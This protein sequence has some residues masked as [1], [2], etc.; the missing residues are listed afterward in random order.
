MDKAL[1]SSRKEFFGN[2]RLALDCYS[3]IPVSRMRPV[4]LAMAPAIHAL[5]LATV[6][7]GMGAGIM[8]SAEPMPLI[9]HSL[10]AME[11][12]L[13]GKHGDH[14][15]TLAEKFSEHHSGVPVVVIDNEALD[16]IGVRIGEVTPDAVQKVV[17]ASGL[18]AHL[19]VPQAEAIAKQ[20]N[21]QSGQQVRLDDGAQFTTEHHEQFAHHQL[22]I[23]MSA[24][25]Q[26]ASPQVAMHTQY[27]PA[28]LWGIHNFNEIVTTQTTAQI[29]T[30]VD[31]HEIHHANDLKIGEEHDEINR[32]RADGHGLGLAEAVG[33]RLA[34]EQV[35]DLG[36]NLHSALEHRDP[37][38]IRETA[39][40]RALNT[41]FQG[42]G[43]AVFTTNP[44]AQATYSSVFYD[45]TPALDQLYDYLHTLPADQF[46]AL[47]DLDH[48]IGQGHTLTNEQLHL[49]NSHINPGVDYS[50]LTHEQVDQLKH[51]TLAEFEDAVTKPF[52]TE[53][54]HNADGTVDF[55]GL[56]RLA[57]IAQGDRSMFTSGDIV[58]RAKLAESRLLTPVDPAQNNGMTRVEAA[59]A[60]MPHI[61]S[62]V[63]EYGPY[64]ADAV[65]KGMTP[66]QARAVEAAHH[67]TAAQ[68]PATAAG[69]GN[70]AGEEEDA[71][72]SVAVGQGNTAEN[73][74]ALSGDAPAPVGAAEHVAA[75]H[76]DAPA[77]HEVST[78]PEVSAHADVP[79]S[80]TAPQFDEAAPSAVLPAATAAVPPPSL[81]HATAGVRVSDPGPRAAALRASIA[82]GE[83]DSSWL[84]KEMADR[85]KGISL[86]AKSGTATIDLGGGLGLRD[87]GGELRVLGK[88][89]RAF[90][91]QF[92]Q[93]VSNRGWSDV[94]IGGNAKFKD[95]FSA[96][97]TVRHVG[98]GNHEVPMR[99]VRQAEAERDRAVQAIRGERSE[100]ARRF[101]EQA[102]RDPAGA[103][104]ERMLTFVER[105]EAKLAVAMPRRPT[106]PSDILRA[107]DRARDGLVARAAE[108]EAAVAKH[109]EGAGLLTRL[110]SRE[111]KRTAADLASAATDAA[112]AAD[113]YP[114]MSRDSAVQRAAINK[115]ANA[116]DAEALKPEAELVEAA[117]TALRAIEKGDKPTIKAVLGGD[118]KAALSS[119]RA[120]A[121]REAAMERGRAARVELAAAAPEE[122]GPRGPRM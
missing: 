118:V 1:A 19:S 25:N 87:G 75:D 11:D 18:D 62:L 6:V 97:L 47:C 114:R 15:K 21:N 13:N 23:T 46:Q 39:D 70:V 55:K 50:S 92:A 85:V 56:D 38:N 35:A 9:D 103:A 122:R 54:H 45:L 111:W 52:R 48:A 84:P 30:T 115:Q 60:K 4:F 95:Y 29:T 83:Y 59:V 63:S 14:N 16:K 5:R 49:L 65:M 81:G 10:A 100:K 120:F 57:A 67:P 82:K 71:N 86:D 102:R 7:I 66:E 17:D 40:A 20:I 44:G 64:G 72:F 119:G 96:Q 73:P 43:A 27:D 104:F 116:R 34:Q 113:K 31:G 26:A 106:D 80:A 112:E 77:P 105:R 33:N 93:A 109:R 121:E 53:V 110:L 90:A 12:V 24:Q 51:T 76:H 41:F 117:K 98:V 107:D 88:F 108:A 37:T 99:L 79:V 91:D 32:L 94:D 68:T 2:E 58:D 8:H 101:A 89:D 78:P 22:A 74:E 3:T 36:G 69:Q 28:N 61:I 42:A